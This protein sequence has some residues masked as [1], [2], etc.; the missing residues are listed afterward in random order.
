MTE[1]TKDKT[2][3]R[4]CLFFVALVIVGILAYT[5]GRGVLIDKHLN[6][7]RDERI[8]VLEIKTDYLVEKVEENTDKV[9]EH[10]ANFAEFGGVP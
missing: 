4:Y 10:S 6:C 8:T 2:S 5:A 7:E 9:E 1:L 3:W